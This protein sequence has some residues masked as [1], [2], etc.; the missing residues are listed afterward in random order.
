MSELTN[1]LL[2]EPKMSAENVCKLY[3]AHN[4]LFKQV[5]SG[6]R[7]NWKRT[8]HIFFV[9]VSA[10]REVTERSMVGEGDAG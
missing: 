10:S 3:I 4:E 6:P 2:H 1:L 9:A 8:D 7:P 5:R